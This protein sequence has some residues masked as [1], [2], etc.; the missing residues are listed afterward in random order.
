MK[1]RR[2]IRTLAAAAAMAMA[3]TACGDNRNG[4]NA[5]ASGGDEGE[6]SG[7]TITIRMG[8]TATPGHSYSRAAEDMI[9]RVTERTD[10]QVEFDLAFSGVLGSEADMTEQVQRGELDI[11]WISDI[12]VSSLAPEIGFV[13]LPYLFPEYEDVEEHYF[14]GFLGEEIEERLAE[15]GL[16]V[17]GWIENDYRALTNSVRPV[18]SVDDLEGLSLRVPEMAMMEDLFREL[19]ASPT[20]IAVT[21]LLT[22]LQQGTV[23]GQDNGIILTWEFGFHEAQEFYTDTRHIYSGGT[24]LVSE[25]TWESWPEDVREV[26]AE[27]MA[28]A[29]DDAREL[30]RED[31]AEFEQKLVDAGLQFTELSEAERERFVEIGRGLWDRYEDEY[32]TELMTRIQDELGG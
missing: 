29:G 12:G 14:G 32:G 21:E 19:G 18:E 15:R 7:E 28:T 11:G 16:R 10:G 6:S 13:T 31:V 20:P 30:N 2:T 3:L 27:E 26:L 23:D 8:S 5:G 1:S 25:E 24:I 22:A 17:L 4:D 9:E